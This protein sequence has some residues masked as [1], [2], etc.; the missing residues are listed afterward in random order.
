V[1]AARAT[2]ATELGRVARL[3]VAL[4]KLNRE[5]LDRLIEVYIRADRIIRETT[6]AD[7]S[8]P[9]ES[10]LSEP[11]EIDLWREIREMHA[12]LETLESFDDAVGAVQKL[13]PPLERFFNEVM[14]M[15]GDEK[16]ANRLQILYRA[17]QYVRDYLG[18]LSQLPR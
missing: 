17:R 10:M 3:A 18:D 5:T 7:W 6:F 1:R 11:A 8:E 12:E 4:G 13:G 15:T 14:V 9:D 16:Q 2:P